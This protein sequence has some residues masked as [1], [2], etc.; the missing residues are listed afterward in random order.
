MR[1]TAQ[2]PAI[3]FFHSLATIPEKDVNSF[4]YLGED[5]SFSK[6]R[7]AVYT[8]IDSWRNHYWQTFGE[9]MLYKTLE[10]ER[11]K[12]NTALWPILGST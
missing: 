4:W 9:S 5:G 11:E 10:W 3:N 2:Y 8:D 12:R 7:D 1:Y 6:C